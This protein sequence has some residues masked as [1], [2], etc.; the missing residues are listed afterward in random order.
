M[1]QTEASDS[2]YID[3]IVYRTLG[4]RVEKDMLSPHRPGVA[5]VALCKPEV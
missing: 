2:S 4:G 1:V 3:E 5:N